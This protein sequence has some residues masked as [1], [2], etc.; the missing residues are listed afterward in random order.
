MATTAYER[1]K[2]RNEVL[3]ALLAFQGDPSELNKAALAAA[4]EH[5]ALP[6]NSVE[7]AVAKALANP[8]QLSGGGFVLNEVEKA[9]PQRGAVHDM[10]ENIQKRKKQ[11]ADERKA[12][13]L[14]KQR[15]RE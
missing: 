7:G 6:S 1:L 15:L 4:L 8:T 5:P 12:E 9:R 14:R 10:T 11:L 3:K 13:E 2:A